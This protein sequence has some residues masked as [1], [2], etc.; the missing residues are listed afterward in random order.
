MSARR[1][2]VIA[3]GG[4]VWLEK[5][6]VSRK[7][8]MTMH[9][10]YLSE[11]L[12]SLRAR[13]GSD[14]TSSTLGPGA[15]HEARSPPSSTC[16]SPVE[17]ASTPSSSLAARRAKAAA[18]SA[19]EDVVWSCYYVTPS[20]NPEHHHGA[21][22]PGASPAMPTAPAPVVL[23]DYC[24]LASV[25]RSHTLPS[26]PVPMLKPTSLATSGRH[27][28]CIETGSLG[29]CHLAL[30]SELSPTGES[31]EGAM[32]LDVGL[33]EGVLGYP[34][35]ARCGCGVGRP[36]KRDDATVMDWS[37]RPVEGSTGSITEARSPRGPLVL[38]HYFAAAPSPLAAQP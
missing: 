14:E 26:S 11:A 32:G 9:P 22:V 29:G 28:P 20:A 3:R 38:E 27:M 19:A 17:G 13:A 21:L 33:I 36:H 4:L 7:I 6:H 5:V 18:L 30:F 8:I 25:I 12:S 2:M 34:D 31:G 1:R 24:I 37:W 35:P 10:V 23:P 16:T 15:E